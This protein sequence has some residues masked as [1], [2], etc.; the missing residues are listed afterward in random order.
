MSI[1]VGAESGYTARFPRT[2]SPGMSLDR[3]IP[4]K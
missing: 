4:T 3:N 1:P 2:G